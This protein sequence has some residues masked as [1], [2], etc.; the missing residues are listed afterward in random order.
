MDP[1]GAVR[2][3]VSG[4]DP[5]AV[6]GIE[7]GATPE[8]VRAAFRK[9]V[10]QQ[11]PDTAGNPVDASAVRDVLEAYRLLADPSARARYDAANPALASGPTAA[12]VTAVPD[13]A[14]PS[15]RS[16]RAVC[17]DC[18]GSGTVRS[19]DVCGSCHG[20]GEITM[21]DVGRA[22]VSGCRACA[23][24]GVAMRRAVCRKCGGS[25]E[26]AVGGRG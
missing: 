16:A 20:S 15:P 8:R 10:R 4:L 17:H 26:V 9:A 21:V 12:S 3:P 22:H 5:Y 7:R 24:R 18:G 13:V 25:G 23:G 19:M 6:L 14:S 11:H 2:C 1:G